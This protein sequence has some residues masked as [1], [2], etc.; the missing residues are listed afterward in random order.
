MWKPED[1]PGYISCLGNC[2]QDFDPER[3]FDGITC[4]MIINQFGMGC[5]DELVGM[6]HIP[7]G[8]LLS[9]MCPQ[10]CKTCCEAPAV[11]PKEE[12]PVVEIWDQTYGTSECCQKGGN[13]DQSTKHGDYVSQVEC[14]QAC[15]AN[16]NCH[17]IE[18]GVSKKGNK[19]R[20]SEE[21]PSLCRCYLVTG[22]C[23]RRKNHGG[24]HVYMKHQTWDKSY[25]GKQ[26]CNKNKKNC[27]QST[28]HGDYVTQMQCQEACEADG[29]CKG[30]EFGVSWGAGKNNKGKN[31]C[32]EK[33]PN[34]CRCYLVT[35]VCEGRKSH[36]GFN[37]YMKP[38]EAEEFP[39][40]PP[41]PTCPPGSIQIGEINAGLPQGQDLSDGAQYDTIEACEQACVDHAECR[42]FSF[43]PSGGDKRV[44][45]DRAV[46]SLFKKDAPTKS[47]GPA[48]VFCKPLMAIAVTKAKC[49]TMQYG[50]LI[51]A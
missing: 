16:D 29:S 3:I 22:S 34:L 36:E 24:Y 32:D 51:P 11:T 17:G 2:C 33:N 30:I 43:A 47:F 8:T 25:T 41:P 39:P 44:D 5:G 38:F 50:G 1:L 20:C 45:H 27:D 31:R 10:T 14:Q 46:C 19:N 26:C 23:N 15:D 6:H 48:Q 49:C 12:E 37:V 42:G 28:K 13:C 21:N 9:H 35:G 40:P 7:P 4:D 18:F